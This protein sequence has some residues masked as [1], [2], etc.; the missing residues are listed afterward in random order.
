[1]N[2]KDMEI[3]E[4]LKSR[5]K[6]LEENQLIRE[7]QYKAQIKKNVEFEVKLKS[8]LENIQSRKEK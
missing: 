5:V 1:M 3:I 2:L 7:H 8:A 6:K 4:D